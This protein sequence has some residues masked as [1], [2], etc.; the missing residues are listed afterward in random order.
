MVRSKQAIYNSDAS[1]P[2]TSI[3]STLSII[4][5]STAPP[6]MITAGPNYD[7]HNLKAVLVVFSVVSSIGPHLNA[8]HSAHHSKR[9]YVMGSSLDNFPRESSE[10]WCNDLLLIGRQVHSDLY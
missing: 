3:T 8:N 4:H 10:P 1:L 2:I 5:C 6:V 7:T 9:P